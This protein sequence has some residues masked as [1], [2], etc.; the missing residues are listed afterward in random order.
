[1]DV[2]TQDVSDLILFPT[3]DMTKRNLW[4][5][6]CGY[7]DDEFKPQEGKFATKNLTSGFCISF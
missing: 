3:N 5:K 2:G 1:M 4:F 7:S 6:L